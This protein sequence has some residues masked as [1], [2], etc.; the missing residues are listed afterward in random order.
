MGLNF[1]VLPTKF[2]TTKILTVKFFV[3]RDLEHNLDHGRRVWKE[4]LC[5]WLPQ[6]YMYGKQQWEKCLFVPGSR[7][8][9]MTGMQWLLKRTVGG[10]NFRG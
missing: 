7:V 5:A 6:I 3:P 1:V 8:T 10:F 9:L 2:D 4:P